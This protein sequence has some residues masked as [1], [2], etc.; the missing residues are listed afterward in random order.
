[1]Q[2]LFSQVGALAG[3]DWQS[4]L[5]ERGRS[6]PKPGILLVVIFLLAVLRQFLARRGEVLGSGI[7]PPGSTAKRPKVLDANTGRRTLFKRRGR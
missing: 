4:F 2:S 3:P 1:V 5:K 6:T 7:D